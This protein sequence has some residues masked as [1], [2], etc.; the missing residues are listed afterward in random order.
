MLHVVQYHHRPQKRWYPRDLSPDQVLDLSLPE[1]IFRIGHLFNQFH[2]DIRFVGPV[3]MQEQR[4]AVLAE[5]HQA[6]IFY[7]AVQPRRERTH[8]SKLGQALERFPARVLDL[9]FRVGSVSDNRRRSP[10]TRIVIPLD[11]FAERSSVSSAR[12]VDES[13]IVLR[14]VVSCPPGL[15]QRCFGG[16]SRRLMPAREWLRS[17]R[18]LIGYVPVG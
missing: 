7:D 17:R 15:F 13:L 1:V 5:P 4:L 9:V 2:T 18:L 16:G 14:D 8:A 3:Q 6:L 12:S 10:E 11:Q